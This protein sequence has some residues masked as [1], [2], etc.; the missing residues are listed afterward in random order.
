MWSIVTGSVV[1]W[2]CTTMPSE[3]PTSRISAPA[4]SSRRAKVA[5]YAVTIAIFSP[6]AFM[7]RNEF[8]VTRTGF[9]DGV[10]MARAV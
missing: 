3:S 1:S 4:V 6:R 8:T 7:A 2:P 9:V 5:S 10:A